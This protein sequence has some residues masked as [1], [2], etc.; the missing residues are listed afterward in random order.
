M[1]EFFYDKISLADLRDE[2]KA[3]IEM[4][5]SNLSDEWFSIT[6]KG[7]ISEQSE[8]NSDHTLYLMLIHPRYGLIFS[9]INCLNESQLKE[10]DQV[11]LFR[12][13]TVSYNE[14]EFFNDLL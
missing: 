7:I 12:D 6:L 1:A 8:T 14:E 3:T 9:N 2:E 10:K 4:I 5:K 11:E 13:L